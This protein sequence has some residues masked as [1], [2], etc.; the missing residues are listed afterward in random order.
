MDIFATLPAD[1][2]EVY[3]QQAAADLGMPAHVVEKDFWVCWTLRRLFALDCVGDDLLFKGGTSLSKAYG[4]IRRFSEDIDISIHRAS[5]GFGGETDPATL[6]GKPFKRTNQALG[7]AAQKKIFGEIQPELEGALRHHLGGERWR[8]ESDA[9]DPEGQSLAFVYPATA[10]TPEAAAYLRPAVK[11]EFGARADHEPAER[12]PVRPYLADALPDALDDPDTEVKVISAVR[13]FWEKAT[14]LHQMAHLSA[15]KKFPVRYSRH[16]CDLA[17]MIDGGIGERA[18][19]DENLLAKVVAHKVEFYAAKWASYETAVGGT[20]RLLPP[21]NRFREI[22]RDLDSM[23]EMFF[24]TPPTIEAV[25]ETLR[26]WETEF[27]QKL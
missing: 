22:G 13:T 14:I 10:L 19:A 6:R 2:R 25:I 9:S 20:L 8:L 4:L 15:E 3:F 12:K 1:E 16:Y 27:N 11:I 17:A 7:E 26:T 23:R 5:L 21:E 18:A 24:D